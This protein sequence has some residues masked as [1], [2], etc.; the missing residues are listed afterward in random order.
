MDFSYLVSVL[1]LWILAMSLV[2]T[3]IGW[4]RMP[5]QAAIVPSVRRF[6]RQGIAGAPVILRINPTIS[7]G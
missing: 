4:L 6:R 1:P 7:R 5:L 3:V 2:I